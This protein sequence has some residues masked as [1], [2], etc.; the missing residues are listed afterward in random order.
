MKDNESR[1]EWLMEEKIDKQLEQILASIEFPAEEEEKITGY[2]ETRDFTALVV[3]A[4]H[5]KNMKIKRNLFWLIFI[6]INIVVLSL[7]GTN[8]FIK[9]EF[10]AFQNDLSILFFLFLG[11]SLFG[12]LIGLVVYFD[13]PWFHDISEWF[14]NTLHRNQ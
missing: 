1:R 8:Q 4:I 9:N 5:E 10:F 3:K 7:L 14:N 11:V 6:I 13:V 2:L 12:G